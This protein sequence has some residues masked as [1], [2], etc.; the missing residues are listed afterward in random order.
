MAKK[1]STRGGTALVI[2]ESP[3]KARTISK[4]LGPN[5]TIE[6]SIGHIRDLPQGA[7]EIPE[8]YKKEDWAY[9]GVDVNHGFRARLCHPSREGPAGPKTQESA[10]G[11]QRTLSGHRRRPRRGGHQLASLRGLEAA[12]ARPQ[13]GF[14][15]NHRRR[16]PQRAEESAPDRRESG[17]G[18]GGSPD[19]R[20][21][22]RLRRVPSAV[23]KDSPA[24]VRR[25]RTE[26]GR[27]ADCRARTSADGLQSRP[28]SG[29]CWATSP[30]RMARNSRRS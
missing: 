7:K 30:S 2:V 4:F 14:P 21:P 3:A 15:R 6:A 5:Y 10:E 19:R 23:E 8:E 12:S 17:P 24:A 27:P 18:P 25:S 16:D 11:R 28:P 9:L 20:S 1:S 13:A 29:T 22:L 26:R